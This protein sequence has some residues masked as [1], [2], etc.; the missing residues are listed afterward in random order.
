[1]EKTNKILAVVAV[2]VFLGMGMNAYAVGGS[3]AAGAKVG[4]EMSGII[5][6]H[7]TT[8]EKEY[9]GKVKDFVVDKERISFVILSHGGVMALGQKLVAVPYDSLSFVPMDRIF[10]L[11]ISK[12]KFEAAPA[13][14]RP[15]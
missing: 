8:P 1:M 12:E 2:L 15:G 4:C 7:V 3:K 6:T 10:T 14:N 5:G 9:L 11:N 13:F